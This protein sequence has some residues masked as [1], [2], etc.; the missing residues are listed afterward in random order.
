MTAGRAGVMSKPATGLSFLDN[1]T[2]TVDS[3]LH[4]RVTSGFTWTVHASTMLTDGT[5]AYTTETGSAEPIAT[6]PFG[7]SDG[8]IE[9]TVPV[10]QTVGISGNCGG[11]FRFV[12]T[13]NFWM[14][15]LDKASGLLFAHKRVA[16]SG[17]NL[18]SFGAFLAGDVFKVTFV[19]TALNFYR[20]GVLQSSQ[21]DSAHQS[22][23]R[24]G[25]MST[26]SGWR[27]DDFR[28]TS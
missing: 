8:T 27:I 22:A 19:G 13:S 2:G 12:D 1:F 17:T 9:F 3:T 6:L 15:F 7:I 26:R 23:T 11:V 24:H 10:L 18:A 5:R 16:G 14:M 20:N 4:G 25:I 21:T 28:V